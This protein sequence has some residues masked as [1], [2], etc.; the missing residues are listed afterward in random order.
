MALRLRKSVTLAPGIR[1]NF[2]SSGMSLS[3]GPRGA[4]VTFGSRGTYLSTGIP[5]TGFSSRTRLDAPPTRQNAGSSAKYVKVSLSVIVNDEGEVRYV[6]D[7]KP[8]PE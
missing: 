5:G 1:L 8:A 7:D 3:A 2:S 6:Y 4:S